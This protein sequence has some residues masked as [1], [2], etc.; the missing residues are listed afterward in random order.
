MSRGL[1]TL[2]AAVLILAGFYGLL[3]GLDPLAYLV[4][5]IGLGIVC[6]VVG[7][8]VHDALTGPWRP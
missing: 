8:L 5:G 6:A 3:H 4:I 1:W 7:S 2:W